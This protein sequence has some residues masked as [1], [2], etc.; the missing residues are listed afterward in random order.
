MTWNKLMAN[1]DFLLEGIKDNRFPPDVI[2]I[3]GKPCETRE[4]AIAVLEECKERGIES[5]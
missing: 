4:Q 2:K 5:I 3:D 1:V